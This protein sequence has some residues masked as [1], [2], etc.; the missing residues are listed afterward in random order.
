LEA[1]HNPALAPPG[2]IVLPETHD[3][4]TRPAQGAI[5]Q[6]IPR[7]IDGQFPPPEFGVV[8]GLGRVTGTCVPETAIHK[9]RDPALGKDEIRPPKDGSVSAPALEVVRPQHPDQ[10]EFSALVAVA[11]DARHEA[12]T[13]GRGKDVRHGSE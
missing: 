1:S 3:S 9:H 10:G 11:A 6:T 2:K 4:P 12:R 8:L 5:H 13:L 7:P